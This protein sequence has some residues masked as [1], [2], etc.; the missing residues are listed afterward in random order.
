MARLFSKATNVWCFS[1]VAS[2]RPSKPHFLIHL[3][4]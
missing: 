2:K 4:V 3:W 1:W